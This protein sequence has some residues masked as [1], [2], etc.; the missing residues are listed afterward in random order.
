MKF[1]IVDIANLADPEHKAQAS[2]PTPIQ[3]HQKYLN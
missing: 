2:H 1:L 3:F